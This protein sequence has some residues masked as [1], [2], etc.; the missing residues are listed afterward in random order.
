[1]VTA[2]PDSPVAGS[3][4]MIEKVWNTRSSPQAA[5]SWAEAGIATASSRDGSHEAGARGANDDLVMTTSRELR[6]IGGRMSRP[7]GFGE[8]VTRTIARCA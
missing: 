3:M 5:G 4:P 8:R 6:W 2:T 7:P 1:M